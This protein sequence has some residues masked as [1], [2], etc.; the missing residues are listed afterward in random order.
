MASATGVTKGGLLHHFDIKRSLLDALFA[1]PANAYEDDIRE[2]VA[3]SPTTYGV[4]IRAY[5]DTVMADVTADAHRPRAT[6]CIRSISDYR[7]RDYW[8]QRMQAMLTCH[9]ATDSDMELS[10]V[11]F[12]ANGYWLSRLLGSDSRDP[13][14]VRAALM[15]RTQQPSPPPD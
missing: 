2:R 8:A 12:A 6:R 9:A 4:F 7:M 15:S 11:C 13:A 3:A 10:L 14:T 1:N 5:I